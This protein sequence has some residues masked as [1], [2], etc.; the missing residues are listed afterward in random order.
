[1]F[2][3]KASRYL[4]LF[5]FKVDVGNQPGVR[6]AEKLTATDPL[7]SRNAEWISVKLPRD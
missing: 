1:M 5:E 6:G 3:K 2:L 4:L 7:T